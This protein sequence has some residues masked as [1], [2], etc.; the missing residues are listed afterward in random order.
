MRGTG[1]S[2]RRTRPQKHATC[3]ARCDTASAD[4]GTTHF[5]YVFSVPRHLTG[6]PCTRYS[7]PVYR[8]TVSV[9]RVRRS[10]A[11]Q[12]L[13]VERYRVP[14]ARRNPFRGSARVIRARVQVF[15]RAVRASLHAVQVSQLPKLK[16]AS[17][18]REIDTR[19]GGEWS[20]CS[21]V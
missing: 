21:V 6:R 9:Q 10:E 11:C 20:T 15:A 14:N 12:Q 4:G 3:S 1:R 7:L 13:F 19:G 18:Y 5:G 2:V 8:Y 16:P 17:V